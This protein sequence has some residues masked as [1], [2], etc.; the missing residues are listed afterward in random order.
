M[1]SLRVCSLYELWARLYT[2]R[3]CSWTDTEAAVNG[4]RNAHADCKSFPFRHYSSSVVCNA[5][6]Y[7]TQ[8]INKRASTDETF[9]L[10]LWF[11]I[12]RIWRSR[13][14]FPCIQLIH[15]LCLSLSSLMD[16]SI[17][18]LNKALTSKYFDENVCLSVHPI[19]YLW[20][21][22]AELHQI[23]VHIEC[24]CGS[25]LLWRR[26]YTL[27]ISGFV[28]DVVFSHSGL[29]GA[30]CIFLSGERIP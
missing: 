16:G 15:T 2:A 24:G 21:R 10:R 25:I 28:D 8:Q 9:Y 7:I 11:V 30:S 23:F 13:N 1:A 26:R 14:V 20:N 27:C 22:V 6:S 5:D 29:Y 4:A 3:Q 19:A 17:D 18:F 12:H